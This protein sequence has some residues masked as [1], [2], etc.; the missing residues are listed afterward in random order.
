[1]VIPPWHACA[2]GCACARCLEAWWG[3]A[4]DPCAYW[5]GR[6]RERR[7]GG[8][9][10]VQSNEEHAFEHAD[11]VCTS[12][13]PL[14]PNNFFP[15]TPLHVFLERVKRARFVLS[16]S[17]TQT[18]NSENP[19]SEPHY[20]AS[21]FPE[22]SR[23]RAQHR[24]YQKQ[25]YESSALLPRRGRALDDDEKAKSS[26]SLGFFRK[27]DS[28]MFKQLSQLYYFLSKT[29]QKRYILACI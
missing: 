21:V 13:L 7:G 19:W 12:L 17:P 27:G 10:G 20:L 29:A 6:P 5:V 16:K 8:G 18:I 14:L 26:S 28:K 22:F 3:R 9:A 1:M 2:V 11:P 23:C 15:T 4:V 25:A 24:R